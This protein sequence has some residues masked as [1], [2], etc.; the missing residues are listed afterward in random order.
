MENV[1]AKELTVGQIREIL[2]K[3]EKGGTTHYGDLLFEGEEIPILA[4]SLSTGL[5]I[6]ELE[7]DMTPSR[8][9]E[10][11][12]EV[13]QANPFFAGMMKRLAKIGEGALAAKNS[14]GPSAG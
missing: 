8:L 7:G 3:L 14:T 1:E 12:E 9:K 13:R 2:E 10:I 6:D 4:V 5:S 11:I